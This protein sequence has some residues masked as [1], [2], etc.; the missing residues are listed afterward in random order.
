MAGNLAKYC[1]ISNNKSIRL[2]VII[3]ME[4]AKINDEISNILK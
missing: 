3:S 1:E 2:A 4:M